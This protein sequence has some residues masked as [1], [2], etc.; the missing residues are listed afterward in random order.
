M[1]TPEVTIAL[2]RSALYEALALGFRPPAADALARISGDEAAEALA[3][4]A[5]LLEPALVPL[6]RRVAGLHPTVEGLR[7]RYTELFGHT[8]RGKV[9]A[10]E[11][12]YGA[13]DQVRQPHELADLTG[14]YGAFG[15]RIAPGAAERPD[16]VR[17]E[18]EFVMSLARREAIASERNDDASRD[19]I[20]R[21]T[22]LFLRD[23]L[24]R[25]APA[26]GERLR[27]ADPDG[28]YGA[29]GA[30]LSAFAMDE[31]QRFEVDV[32]SAVL[33]LRDPTED[34]V[35]MACGSCDLGPEGPVED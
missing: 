9:P 14:F 6:V 20:R 16:H 4:A 5:S 11:T 35:P 33:P 26:L 22:R 8:A 27:E 2:S 30:L 25:F 12:E 34:A 7:E 17:C 23:H 31:C 1:M 28:F 18:C 19:Q 3:D 21:A 29:L 10:F 24:G 15:L 32:G 13:D